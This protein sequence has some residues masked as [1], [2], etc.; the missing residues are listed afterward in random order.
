VDAIIY[1]Y[2]QDAAAGDDKTI[3]QFK[4]ERIQQAAAN[5][6]SSTVVKGVDVVQTMASFRWVICHLVNQSIII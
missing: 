6:S 5:H 4:L 2:I 1:Y 3:L